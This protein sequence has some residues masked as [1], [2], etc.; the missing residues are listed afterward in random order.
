[1]DRGD[2]SFVGF[3]AGIDLVFGSV[4]DC[5]W[6]LLLCWEVREEIVVLFFYFV[7]F[8]LCILAL[9]WTVYK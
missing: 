7:L 1:M 5:G 9:G 3:G 8:C 4:V 2:L 6:S